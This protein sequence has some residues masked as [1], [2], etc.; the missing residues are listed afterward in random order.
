MNKLKTLVAVDFS[1]DSLRVLQKAMNFTKKFNGVVHI[2]HVV[3]NSFF[4]PKKDLSYIRE[5]SVKKLSEKFPSIND[6]NF[7]CVNGKIKNEVAKAAQI[8]NSDLIIMGKSGET[9]FLGDA[10]MGSH[11]KDIIRNSPVPVLVVKSDHELKY[12]NILMLTDFSNDSREA[13]RRVVNIFPSLNIK[14]LNFYTIPFENRLN[15]YGFN[16]T[17]IIDYQLSLMQE[18]EEKLDIFINSLELPKD[19]NI[20][21]KVRK[22]SLNP[23]LFESEVKDINFD[24]VAVHTTGSVS[25]YALDILENSK[26]DVVI[27]KV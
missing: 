1:D 13:I 9:Y 12:K 7:H 4:S 17:D 22:S 10:Y 8:L 21:G 11:T 23:K 20:S 18:S 27:L 16:N 15:T 6:E 26:K 25:F 5:H 19:I 14:L 3:E 24:L 2:V